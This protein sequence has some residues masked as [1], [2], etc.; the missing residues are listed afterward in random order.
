MSMFSRTYYS[1]STTCIHNQRIHIA[2]PPTSIHY[3]CNT[4]NT[5][6][7]SLVQIIFYTSCQIIS[8]REQL[9]K[10]LINDNMQ[11]ELSPNSHEQRPYL[12]MVG[13][14][15]N[16]LLCMKDKKLRP[17]VAEEETSTNLRH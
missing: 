16:L 10:K 7:I 12:G 11:E 1:T 9:T 13:S 14:L 5:C 2:S 15:Q 4:W 3:T 8:P 6:I 17:Q